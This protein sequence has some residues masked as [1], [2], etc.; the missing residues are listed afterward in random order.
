MGFYLRFCRVFGVTLVLM[1]S[2]G[3]ASLCADGFFDDPTTRPP[4]FERYKSPVWNALKSPGPVA[5]AVM[6]GGRAYEMAL[7]VASNFHTD[8]DAP[9]SY[10]RAMALAIADSLHSKE[11]VVRLADHQLKFRRTPNPVTTWPDRE[12]LGVALWTLA[13]KAQSASAVKLQGALPVL[14]LAAAFDPSDLASMVRY[15][16]LSAGK[17]ELR[18]LGTVSLPKGIDAPDV[19]PDWQI[20]EPD[21]LENGTVQN[22][23]KEEPTAAFAFK[24]S[25]ASILVPAVTGDFA[26]L[27][28]AVMNYDPRE[29]RAR[30]KVAAREAKKNKAATAG[31]ATL[32]PPALAVDFHADTQNADSAPLVLIDLARARADFL[33]R[34]AGAE[35]PF[36]LGVE[37]RI[38]GGRAPRGGGMLSAAAGILLESMASGVPLVDSSAAAGL[39]GF[40]STLALGSEPLAAALG[41]GAEGSKATRVMAVPAAAADQVVDMAALGEYQTLMKLQLLGCRRL[42]DAMA[43]LAAEPRSEQARAVALFAD[44]GRASERIAPD[45]LL[46]NPLVRKR[47]VEVVELCPSHLS[48]AALL[49]VSKKGHAPLTA[50][51]SGSVW[52]LGQLESQVRGWVISHLSDNE[53]AVSPVSN[54][55]AVGSDQ[56]CASALADLRLIR[57]RLHPDARRYADDLAELVEDLRDSLRRGGSAAA[58]RRA[59]GLRSALDSLSLEVAGIGIAEP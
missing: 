37:F 56:T 2:A 33:R 17:M 20:A 28:A 7:A 48:A 31:K 12:A 6:V 24:V 53:T 16:K 50:S 1:L 58:V 55:G 32:E 35:V 41:Q 57:P 4:G 30:Y 44:I 47:L 26:R 23:A 52:R 59:E 22:E 46:R 19:L 15:R 39:L 8:E 21:D 14:D 3:I 27:E 34:R 54:P 38:A 13:W 29:L 43:I 25:H 40:G 5:E 42:D 11:K 36:G 51:L 18:W 49:Q 10:V 45:A 9:P